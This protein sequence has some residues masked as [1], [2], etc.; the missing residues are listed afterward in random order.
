MTSHP[1]DLSDT[2]LKT[3][4]ARSNVCNHIHLPLQAGSNKI[5]EAM[6]RKYSREHYADL[7]AK[8]RDLIPNLG[9]TTDVMVGF[10]GETETEF[11]ETLDLMRTLRFDDAFMYHYSVREGT[12]AENLHDQVDQGEKLRRLNLLIKM[13]RS[14]S[15]EIKQK[16]VGRTVEA[17]AESIS[18]LSDD[19]WL[20]KTDSHQPVVFPKGDVKQG[21][22]AEIRI[23]ACRG[24]TLRGHV[25]GNDPANTQTAPRRKACQQCG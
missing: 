15:S 9:L 10:P 24:N 11:Q 5:L 2:L 20:G 14:I 25:V 1:K 13:Q 22:L 6:N 8:A 19:E 7:V 17:L 4:A 16:M 23:D 12:K 18:K 21:D 3:I